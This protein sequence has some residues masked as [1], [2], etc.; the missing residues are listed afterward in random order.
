LQRIRLGIVGVGKVAQDQHIPALRATDAFSLVACASRTCSIEGLD[1]FETVIDMLDKRTDIEAVAICTPPQ[2]H[3]RAAKCA[4]GRGK[5]VL[6]EKP[7]CATIAEFDQL[8]HLAK[9]KDVTL[10]QTWHARHGAAVDA[11]ARW[12]ESC[13]ILRGTI[14]WKEDVR[15]WHPGQEWIWQPGGFG[16]LD[17]GINAVSIL[18]Q[19]IAEP[20]FVE[21]AQLFV[22]SN[23]E[24]PIAA[25]VTF[26][27][28]SNVMIEAEFDFRHRGEMVCEIELDTDRGSLVLTAYGN[29]LAINGVPVEL[30]AAEGEY[31]SL[32][33]RFAELIRHGES[34]VDGRPL[35]LIADIFLVGRQSAVEAFEQ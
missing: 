31:L 10:F 17:A 24:A 8:V 34:D 18:T 30:N 15:H 22:P 27:T 11:A 1:N 2:S 3:Y 33:R 28:D 13:R 4:L 19:I 29:A 7:P 32:Y 26:T 14:R 9:A 21:G 20:L 5:H 6:L 23:R 16:V 35:K 12:L 25:N